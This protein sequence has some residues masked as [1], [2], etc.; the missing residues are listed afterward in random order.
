MVVTGEIR[1]TYRAT[2]T[3][4]PGEDR[5]AER[6][7]A[8]V[9]PAVIRRVGALTYVPVLSDEERIHLLL[10]AMERAREADVPFK[11]NALM[12]KVIYGY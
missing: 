7:A 2:S 3:S 4:E 11:P 6:I 9:E 12:R 8:E 10:D 1:A 5:R